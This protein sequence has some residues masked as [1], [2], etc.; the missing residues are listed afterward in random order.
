MKY[1]SN[2][3]F[4]PQQTLMFGFYAESQGDTFHMVS[5]KK[6]NSQSVFIKC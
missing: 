4:S 5:L 2:S 6:E 3:Q 1:S